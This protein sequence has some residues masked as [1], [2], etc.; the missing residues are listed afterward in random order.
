MPL[1]GA[2]RPSFFAGERPGSAPRPLVCGPYADVRVTG[3]LTGGN[4]WGSNP[5]TDDSD[6]NV[7]AVHAGIVDV[8]ETATISFF[9][10][11]DYSTTAPFYT[12][13]TRNGVTTR[14]WTT[15]WCGAYIRRVGDNLSG[16]ASAT[17]LKSYFK[18]LPGSAYRITTINNSSSYTKIPFTMRGPASLNVAVTKDNP[19]FFTGNVDDGWY[20]LDLGFTIYFLGVPYTKIFVGT[21]S[22]V[23]FGSGS[24]RYS[25]LNYATPDL[26]KI[27]ISSA[28]N[29][30]QRLYYGIEGTGGNRTFRIRWEGTNDLHYRGPL[31][32]D[33]PGDSNMLWEMI[34][35]ENPNNQID[36]HIERN[37]R[38]V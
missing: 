15:R 12:S 13:S 20:E 17:E 35:F 1:L 6:W 7:A 11:A 16:V 2:A 38:W 27:M 29:S 22:Y 28:D 26:P 32:Y 36:L 24:S 5:Y 4:V 37:A 18:S 19:A 10:A 8:G 14:A 30:L 25:G 21:N 31:G 33:E 34:F 23:T 3:A 9:D